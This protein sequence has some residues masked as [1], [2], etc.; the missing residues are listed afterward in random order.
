M[1]K[2]GGRMEVSEPKCFLIFNNDDEVTELVVP[3]DY[4]GCPT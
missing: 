1:S 4:L 3:V 2:N